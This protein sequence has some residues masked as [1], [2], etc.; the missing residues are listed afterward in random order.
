MLAVALWQVPAA[1][2]MNSSAIF[3]FAII[4]FFL[5]RKIKSDKL[6][7]I[8]ALPRY[9]RFFPWYL[10]IFAVAAI[11]LHG[12]T[13]IVL[14]DFGD[15]GTV[16]KFFT[17]L[18]IPSAL[19]YVG[20]GVQIRKIS[21]L[22]RKPHKKT[23]RS[24]FEIVWAK[25]IVFLSIVITPL[26]IIPFLGTALILGIIPKEWFIVLTINAILPITSTNMFLVT[27]GINKKATALS[28]AWTTLICVPIVVLLITLFKTF[29]F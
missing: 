29:P 18:T 4:P 9:L 28:V 27:Y 6:D 23:F 2:Y 24:S 11:I 16:F 12:T 3:L 17:A 22:I 15:L 21:L 26:L 13:G 20:A 5:S 8:E 19:Y 14:N 1:I 10:L 25:F 7:K